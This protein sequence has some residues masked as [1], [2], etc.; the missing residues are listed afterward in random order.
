MLYVTRI[1][2]W[3]L[4][5]DTNS[6][7]S[8]VNRGMATKDSLALP[9]TSN[10]VRSQV[11][12]PADKLK[13]GLI[14][15]LINLVTFWK[16]F[17]F[18][19]QNKM[20]RDAKNWGSIFQILFKSSK[21]K[22]ELIKLSAFQMI[23]ERK[24]KGW[25]TRRD[26]RCSR[27]ITEVVLSNWLLM[28]KVLSYFLFFLDLKMPRRPVQAPKYKKLCTLAAFSFLVWWRQH[29]LPHTLCSIPPTLQPP[30]TSPPTASCPLYYPSASTPCPLGNECVWFFS[31]PLA[32]EKVL[33]GFSVTSY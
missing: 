2:S 3:P 20:V 24:P 22:E 31:P 9:P 25:T 18:F 33:A 10:I 19:L 29:T 8:R 16:F 5:C 28:I 6:I 13:T 12:F 30:E 21:R 26:R 7:M 14:D 11:L 32:R 17:F 23:K 4:N 27:E 1:V 15:T